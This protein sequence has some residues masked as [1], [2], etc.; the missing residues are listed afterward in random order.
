M[1]FKYNEHKAIFT[2]TQYNFVYM[3]NTI[4][5]VLLEQN[6]YFVYS[7]DT[8]EYYLDN[9]KCIDFSHIRCFDD[10][11]K[12]ADQYPME[13]I[14]NEIEYL[15]EFPRLYKPQQIVETC[16]ISDI[17]EIDKIVKKY[18]MK[19]GIDCVRGGSYVSPILCDF[20]YK[21][22][23]M[24]LSANKN[25][26]NEEKMRNFLYQKILTSNIEKS[27]LSLRKIPPDR[28]GLSVYDNEKIDRIVLFNKYT[29]LCNK[30]NKLQTKLYDFM[31]FT[32]NEI[33]YTMD[34]SIFDNFDNIKKYLCRTIIASEEET[35]SNLVG[36]KSDKV[37]EAD[38]I[39]K[40]YNTTMIY[41][42]HV[43]YLIKKYNL[44]SFTDGDFFSS[45]KDVPNIHKINFS[46]PHF[47]LD[48]VILHN[49]V[50]ERSSRTVATKGGHLI[51]LTSKMTKGHRRSLGRVVFYR[52]LVDGEKRSWQSK[53]SHS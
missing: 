3:N 40:I 53:S 36:Q 30:K 28:K 4:Y 32:K 5:V 34:K 12:N 8:A 14:K 41:V 35:D 26:F 48:K 17:F 46:F 19:Y 49:M 45:G 25:R 11:R 50:R 47:L 38:K 9:I 24:E 37:K 1:F 2:Y 20:Q 31:Y 15:F 44:E 29:I 23:E 39:K 10:F 52:F 7:T 6:K 13:L 21:A 51:Q 33:Q 42:N 18:M 43:I 27:P 22:L 16:W